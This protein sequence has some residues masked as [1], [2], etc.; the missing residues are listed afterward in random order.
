MIKDNIKMM[1]I[2]EHQRTMRISLLPEDIVQFCQDYDLTL[3]IATS[4]VV[5]Y[6]QDKWGGEIAIS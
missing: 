5:I 3:D 1:D 6:I 2:D 4:D